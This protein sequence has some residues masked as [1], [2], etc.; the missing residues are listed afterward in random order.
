MDSINIT[1]LL[2]E[3]K[4][5]L[6]DNLMYEYRGIHYRLSGDNWIILAGSMVPPLYRFCKSFSHWSSVTELIV[7][8]ILV[9]N[10]ICAKFV[11]DS[12]PLSPSTAAS[13][14]TGNQ[15]SGP[16]AF[17]KSKIL[18]NKED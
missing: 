6:D 7:N 10:Q 18:N 3:Y 15:R 17:E 1:D 12:Y 9:P 5:N 16:E 14:A 8:R 2:E 4:D 13:I 11:R